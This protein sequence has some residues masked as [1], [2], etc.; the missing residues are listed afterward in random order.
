MS[1]FQIVLTIVFAFVTLGLFEYSKYREEQKA[2]ADVRS[3]LDRYFRKQ[4]SD[5]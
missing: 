1:L 2:K 4:L 3:S 5:R